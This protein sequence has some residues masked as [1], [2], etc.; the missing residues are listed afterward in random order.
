MKKSISKYHFLKI[1][2]FCFILFLQSSCKKYLDEKS[3]KSLVVLKTLS[4]LQA[5]LDDNFLM[6]SSTP[7]FG[8][9]STDDFFLPIDMYNSL[10][11]NAQKEYRWQLTEYR[12]P[13]DWADN[14]GTVFNS[15][16]CLE[17]IETV[18]KTTQNEANWN[19]VKGSALFFRG[20][21]FLNLIW[22][23]GKAFDETTSATDLGIVLRL[24]SDF[25]IPSKR[26]SVQESYNQIITDLYESAKY[27]PLHASHPMRP[28]KGASFAAL[29]RTYLSTKNYDSAYKYANLA[30]QVNDELID[31][32]GGEVDLNSDNPFQP[33]NRE[34]IFYS[35]QSFN[36]YIQNPYY[37]AI[38]T[39][40]YN[41]YPINDLRN[42]VYFMS[43]N[44]YHSFKGS[45][46]GDPYTFFTGLANDE[47]YLIRAECSARMANISAALIDLNKLLQYRFASGTFTPINSS[48]QQ[49][50]L[51]KILAERRKELLMRGLRWIDIKRLNKEGRSI[52]LKRV[53][54]S[55]EYSLV[56][57]ANKY[58]LPLPMDIIEITGMQQN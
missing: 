8:E 29:A 51:D 37:A 32:N 21:S 26:A 2:I 46:T 12:Y 9:A 19:N 18:G 56:P 40:L 1:G 16:Y 36:H 35:T 7:G 28:S 24:K 41:S 15:N 43:N 27:L 58:A 13:S 6:N 45:Y 42:K 55:Q 23:Y 3:D 34:V 54:S 44:G 11:E 52:T 25:N 4:D 22:E 38:D 33:F 10:D 47:L 48:N 39:L 14:Y 49:E 20:Y 17:Q 53:I 31:Y 5:L 57:N 50:V 30:L